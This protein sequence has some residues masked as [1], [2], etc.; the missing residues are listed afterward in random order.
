VADNEV[1]RIWKLMKSISFCMLSNWKGKKLHSRPIGAFARPDE[2]AV[3][4]FTDERAHDL[5]PTHFGRQSRQA[6][7]LSRRGRA[8]PFFGRSSAF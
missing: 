5:A 2:G 1:E 3:S 7:G 4:F 8:G 6:R